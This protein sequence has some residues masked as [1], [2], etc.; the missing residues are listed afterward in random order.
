LLQGSGG[1]RVVDG[2]R[3]R[4]LTVRQ[5]ADR[6]GVCAAMVYGLVERGELLHVRV[7]NAIRVTLADLA[8]FIAARTKAG[9]ER[10]GTTLPR[11]QQSALQR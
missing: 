4:L 1:L 7:S 10:K 6:L 5:V 2:G 9:S 11:R 3:D 8:A